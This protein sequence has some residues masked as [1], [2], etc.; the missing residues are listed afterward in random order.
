MAKISKFRPHESDY[1]YWPEVVSL[2]LFA[3]QS[4]QTISGVADWVEAEACHFE[5]I[6]NN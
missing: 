3:I 4:A 6:T 2:A 5:T 1:E